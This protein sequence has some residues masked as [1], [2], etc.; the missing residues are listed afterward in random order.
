[1]DWYSKYF[2]SYKMSETL[3]KLMLFAAILFIA[4]S[5]NHYGGVN[6]T[7]RHYSKGNYVSVTKKQ[8]DFV[9]HEAYKNDVPKVKANQETAKSRTIPKEEEQGIEANVS[10]KQHTKQ[11]QKENRLE[12]LINEAAVNK[13]NT[14]S[15]EERINSLRQFKKGSSILKVKRAHDDDEARSLFWLVVTI[16]L[17]IWLIAL[18]SGGWGLGGLIHVILVI[19][20][21][22]FILWLL[23]LI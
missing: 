11:F 7:K 18:L 8:K 15:R 13:A 6:I 19:A 9:Q 5:C 22:L 4:S 1:M 3:N 23:K 21:I 14:A 17:I 20:L 2:N 10:S 12:V 16:L